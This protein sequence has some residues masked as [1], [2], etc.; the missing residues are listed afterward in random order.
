[1]KSLLCCVFLV[2]WGMSL[3]ARAQS[4]FDGTWKIDLDESQSSTTQYTYLLQDGIYHCPSCDPP[5]E[6]KAD[7]KDHKI[8]REECYDTV[9]LKVVDA[10]TTEETDKR[11]GKTVGTTR[12]TVST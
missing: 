9:S 11:D 3:Q 12:M 6:V 8:S 2:S 7:G 10:R 4:L 5:L 1:M